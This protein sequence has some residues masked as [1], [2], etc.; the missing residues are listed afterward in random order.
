MK[1]ILKDVFSKEIYCTIIIRHADGS[2]GNEENLNHL[3]Y[4]DDVKLF[5]ENKNEL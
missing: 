4:L 1:L 5:A 3:T 2:F